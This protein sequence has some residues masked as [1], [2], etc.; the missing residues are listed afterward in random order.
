MLK[1]ELLKNQDLK[2]KQFNE[3]T[4]PSVN[5]DSIIGVR[6]PVLRTIAKS[7]K[8]SDEYASF[9]KSL[10]HTYFEENHIHSILL[11]QINDFDEWLSCMHDFVPYIDNWATCDTISCKRIKSHEKELEPS[12]HKWIQSKETYIIRI[13]IILLMKYYLKDCFDPKYLEWVK[14]VQSD[15]YYVNMARAWFFQDAL[16]KQYDATIP[17]LQSNALDTWTHNKAI[18]K[19]VESLKFDQ[20]TKDYFKSMR[21]K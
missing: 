8:K 16:V 20:Q 1:D 2:Y 13:G 17:Y 10:P 6:V 18:Q 19:C 3:M 4:M 11:G 9:M 21:R 14:D 7:F 15:E 12:V 5:P